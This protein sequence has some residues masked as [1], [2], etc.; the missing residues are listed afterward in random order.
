MGKG[1]RE[2]GYRK[3]EVGNWEAKG[4]WGKKRER[5]KECRL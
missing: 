4:M 5:L 2:V 3:R 1:E